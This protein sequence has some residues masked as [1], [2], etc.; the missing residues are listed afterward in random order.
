MLPGSSIDQAG[1]PSL[2][3][4]LGRAELDSAC[5]FDAEFVVERKSNTVPNWSGVAL[6]FTGAVLIYPHY[7][8]DWRA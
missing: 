5:I 6:S 3:K 8:Y 2:A 4:A 7:C 1:D